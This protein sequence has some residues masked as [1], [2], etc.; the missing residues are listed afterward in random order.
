MTTIINV[1]SPYIVEIN[2]VGQSNSKVELFIWNGSGGAP[3]SPTYTLSKNVPSP[4]KVQTVYNISHYVQEYINHNSISVVYNTITPTPNSHWCNVRIKKYSNGTLID[5]Y[6]VFAVNGYGQYNDGYNPQLNYALID[7]MTYYYPYNSTY[8][9][10]TYPLVRP[11]MFTVFA[12][13][14]FY[15]RWTNLVTGDTHDNAL[16]PDQFTNLFT[17]YPLYADSGNHVVV[18]DGDDEIVSEFTM[19]P[20]DECKYT[21]IAVDYVNRYG[22]WQRQHFFKASF[23]SIDVKGDEFNLLQ[24]NLVNYDV[25]EGQRKVFNKNGTDKITVNSGF[26]GDDFANIM[27]QI[28]LSERILVDG[29]PAICNTS[30]LDKQKQLNTKL[31]NYS[32]EFNFAYDTIN[33]V[34]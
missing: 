6:D 25:M 23:D 2:E 9:L 22:A 17:V 10:A 3:A 4:T 32:V 30:T 31:I 19:R 16:T 12:Y 21:P 13:N 7:Q 33:S 15:V 24:S 29:K 8:D 34:V 28:L 27:Q 26:V 20:I 5:A 11:S 18:Y 14:S 1:R